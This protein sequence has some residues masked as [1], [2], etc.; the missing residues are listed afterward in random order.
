MANTKQFWKEIVKA[1]DYDAHM[2]EAGQAEVNA[3]LI[4]KIFQEYP[5]SLGSLIY[6]PGCGTG[7]M[8]DFLKPQD[9]GNFKFIFSDIKREFIAELEKRIPEGTD[10]LIV[11]DDLEESKINQ[12]VSAALI[13]L[14]LQH[15]DWK[16]ALNNIVVTDPELIFLIEQEQDASDGEINQNR[17]LRPT[18]KAFS[19]K[20]RTELIGRKLLEDE[21]YN[22]GYRLAWLKIESVPFRKRMFAMVFRK[23]SKM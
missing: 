20:A 2:I 21:L 18:M 11:L 14:V 15:I 16:L 19:E 7:Q 23:T 10:C 6:V 13:V 5:L 1:E 9:L 8:F 4:Q 12:K 22:K 17:N 3:R